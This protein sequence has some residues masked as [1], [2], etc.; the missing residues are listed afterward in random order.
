MSSPGQGPSSS[1]AARSA[2]AWLPLAAGLA[3]VVGA[4]ALPAPAH[5]GVVSLAPLYAGSYATGTGADASFVRINGDWQGSSVLWSESQQAFGNGAPGG[6][7]VAIGTQS[8]GTG[9]WGRADWAQVQA[10]AAG[11]GGAGAPTVLQQV[12][13][14]GS[15]INYGNSRYNECY[16]G[17]WG[18][19]ELAPMLTPFGPLGNCSDPARGDALHENWTSHFHGYIRIAEAGLYN[20]SVLYDD[21]FFFNLVGAG[22]QTLGIEQDF[23]NPRNRLGFDE[24]LLLTEGLYAFELG[25][26]NRLAAGVVDLRWARGGGESPEWTLVPT[27]NLLPASAVPEPATL[28]LLAAALAATVGLVRRRA[29][30]R[31]A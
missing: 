20:F 6:S 3:L 16:S 18:A 25:S 21:G 15:T 1:R 2:G 19:A 5:A 13:G 7:Y 10:A 30:A 27:E 23:L 14:M 12:N 4:A 11:L 9:L 31:R 26:W 29:S 22:S 28:P 8:W 17:T 24:D